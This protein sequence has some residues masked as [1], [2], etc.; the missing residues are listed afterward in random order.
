MNTLDGKEQSLANQCYEKLQEHILNGTFAP[1]QKLKVDALKQEFDIGH[2]PIREA[3]SR[4]SLQDWLNPATTKGFVLL[5]SLK[6]IF[7]TYTK[8]FF[9]SNYLHLRKQ[10]NMEMMLGNRALLQHF[11]ISL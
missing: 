9:T 5:K 2:S 10:Y 8:R 11:I 3:L 1:G 6:P 7:T 4:L